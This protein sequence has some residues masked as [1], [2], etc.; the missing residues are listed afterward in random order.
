V[1]SEEA[2]PPKGAAKRF[3]VGLYGLN[4]CWRGAMTGTF[5]GGDLR[6]NK[7]LKSKA[8]S[9]REKKKGDLLK[10]SWLFGKGLRTILTN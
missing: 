9:R 7:S 1:I 3:L 8:K 6:K 2:R 5:T 10:S 4:Y